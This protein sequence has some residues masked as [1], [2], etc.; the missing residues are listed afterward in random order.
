MKLKADYVLRQIA[1]AWVVL[2]I[3]ETAVD[4][5]GMLRLNESGAMLW[6]ILE[7][8]ADKQALVDALTGEYNV[9]SVQADA[10]VEEFL[11]KLVQAGCLE[12]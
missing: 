9:S 3:G 12:K 6:R 7:Q 10:D 11:D 5:S 1:G 2:P 8:E 4:F